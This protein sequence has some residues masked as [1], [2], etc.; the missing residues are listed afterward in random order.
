VALARTDVCEE[1]IAII[2]RAARIG[3]SAHTS[4]TASHGV[5]S[6]KTA[7]FRVIAIKTSNLILALTGWALQWRCN[8]SPVRYDVGFYIPEDG[9]LRSS[10]RENAKS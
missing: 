6:Q 10:L 4:H 5:T 9:I 2:I 7:F 8:V 3:V 1:R